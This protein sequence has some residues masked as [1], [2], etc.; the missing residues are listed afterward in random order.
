MDDTAD[1]SENTTGQTDLDAT[2]HSSDEGYTERVSDITSDID[3]GFFYNNVQ[4]S[5][6]TLKNKQLS[7][8]PREI[9]GEVPQIT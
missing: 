6:R 1:Q 7:E 9:Y 5:R 3:G 2:S 8:C 4:V